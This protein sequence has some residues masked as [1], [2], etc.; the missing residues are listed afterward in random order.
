MKYDEKTQLS[1]TRFASLTSLMTIKNEIRDKIRYQKSVSDIVEL[2]DEEYYQDSV[3]AVIF[4]YRI[5]NLGPN[6]AP[7]QSVFD[8]R[9][10]EAVRPRIPKKIFGYSL[11][12]PNTSDYTKF[13][14]VF[15]HFGNT[16]YISNSSVKYNFK[17]TAFDSYNSIDIYKSDSTSKDVILT[18]T[19][20]FSDKVDTFKRSV[21]NLEYYFTDGELI[22][23]KHTGKTKFLT[24]LKPQNKIRENC[25]ITMDIETFID[26]G[27]VRPFLISYFDGKISRSFYL[28]DFSSEDEMILFCLMSIVKSKYNGY[29]VYLHNLS[30]FDSVFLMR[31][32]AKIADNM[33][34][35]PLIK[36]GRVIEFRVKLGK[37]RVRFRDSLLM[38]PVSLKL[39]G[40]TFNVEEKGQFPIFFS[41]KETLNY[42]GELPDIRYFK[43]INL[44]EYN[45]LKLNYGDT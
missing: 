1:I 30:K 11:P 21:K 4:K 16:Y 25:V 15:S 10:V 31:H 18:V 3:A 28:S 43:D 37:V 41:S 6:A 2:K 20:Y 42:V 24:S 34:R 12:L 7:V 17:V 39:L 35:D 14:T 8:T 32:L 19:D 26:N 13:G 36:D 23:K 9:I 33:D 40:S 38:L 45:A 5:I 27:V 22:L 44:E 29:I